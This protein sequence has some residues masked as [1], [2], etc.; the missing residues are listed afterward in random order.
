QDIRAGLNHTCVYTEFGARIRCWGA[1]A[2]M[3]IAPTRPTGTLGWGGFET[4]DRSQ[5]FPIA[6]LFVSS[7]TYRV[8]ALTPASGGQFVS[9][10]LG[11]ERLADVVWSSG[12]APESTLTVCGL[13]AGAAPGLLCSAVP[14][15]D[16]EAGNGTTTPAG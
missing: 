2:P 4:I 1:S 7:T 8:V 12:L 10:T 14:N 13:N 11:N 5:H 3:P 16:G 6:W 15:Q 9:S